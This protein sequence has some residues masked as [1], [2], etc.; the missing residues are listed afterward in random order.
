MFPAR[1]SSGKHA[2]ATDLR[3]AKDVVAEMISIAVPDGGG[4][5]HRDEAYD[6]GGRRG[7][8]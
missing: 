4:R 5:R 7:R 2:I 6:G 8:E 3:D 1:R